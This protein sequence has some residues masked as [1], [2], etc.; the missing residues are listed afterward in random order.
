M[1]R[2]C[3][4]VERVNSAIKRTVGQ[5]ATVSTLRQTKRVVVFGLN[6]ITTPEEVEQAFLL[7][8]GEES[9]VKVSMS[10]MLQGQ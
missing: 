4:S 9:A 2:D 6:E 8:T 7:E 1:G 5:S 3:N 10:K